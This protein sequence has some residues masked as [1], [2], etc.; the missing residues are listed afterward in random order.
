MVKKKKGFSTPLEVGSSG[1]DTTLPGE[2]KLGL[3]SVLELAIHAC[4]AIC[5]SAKT[6]TKR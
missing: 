5:K 1:V 3:S 4:S 6:K 2:Y